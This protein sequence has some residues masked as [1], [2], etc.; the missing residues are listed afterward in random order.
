M[1]KPN[2]SHD[3]LISCSASFK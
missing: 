2:I 1:F 3:R